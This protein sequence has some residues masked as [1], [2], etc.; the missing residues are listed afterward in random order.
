MVILLK[1]GKLLQIRRWSR[2]ALSFD[3]LSYYSTFNIL[4]T[5]YIRIVLNH[6]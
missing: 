6:F 2:F 1:N 5:K 3:G 4:K